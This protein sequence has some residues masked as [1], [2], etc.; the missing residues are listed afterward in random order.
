MYVN[1]GGKIVIFVLIMI[2]VIIVGIKVEEE[3]IGLCIFFIRNL[4]VFCK[5]LIIIY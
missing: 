5:V 3:L 1:Y 2:F 4:K